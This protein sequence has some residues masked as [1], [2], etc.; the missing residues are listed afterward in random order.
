MTPTVQG[1]GS[2]RAGADYIHLLLPPL[3]EK[4]KSGI[5]MPDQTRKIRN[6]GRVLS[7]GHKVE[8]AHI[9]VGD[10]IQFDP[11]GARAIKFS[12]FQ[13]EMVVAITEMQILSIV[14]DSFL[15]EHNLPMPGRDYPIPDAEEPAQAG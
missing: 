8:D 9:C 10:V 2:C 11:N 7:K 1:R 13:E 5:V 6:Y 14:N 4:T 15:T 3:H 12:E